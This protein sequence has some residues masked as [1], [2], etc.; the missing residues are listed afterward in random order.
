MAARDRK[1]VIA[2]I[3]LAFDLAV[4]PRMLR[5]S[6]AA[7]TP[8]FRRGGQWRGAGSQP[9]ACERSIQGTAAPDMIR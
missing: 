1:R 5:F 3:W 9:L 4:S 8:R 2:L 7:G 6:G